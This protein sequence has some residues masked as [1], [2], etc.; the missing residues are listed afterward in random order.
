[1]KR[2]ILTLLAV[3]LL[4]VSSAALAGD[5]D[6][7]VAWFGKSGMA[8][9]VAQSMEAR[10]AEIAPQIK[11]EYQKELADA[12]AL[13]L[14]IQDFQKNKA[15]MVLLRSNGAK[16]VGKV[17]PSIPAFIGASNHPG[18]LGVIQNLDAPEGNITG[19]S[20]A[21]SAESQFSTFSAVVP[22]MKSVFLLLEEGHPSSAINDADTK[23]VCAKLGY[24]FQ[25]RLFTNTDDLLAAVSAEKNNFSVFL[26]GSQAMVM[27]NTA[28][29]VAAAGNTPALAYAQK[30]VKDGA[31]CGL[32]ADD[33]KL[34]ALLAESVVDALVNGQSVSSIPVKFDTK[35]KLYINAAAVEK[36]GLEIPFD[37][38][39][40]AEI[41]E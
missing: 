15:G 17:S 19:V 2:T 18:H 14:A 9:R 1:M 12:A 40:L 27:D 30:P 37:I 4:I 7:G 41:I 26:I 11:L 31:L 5:N 10:L 22:H 39:S 21:L 16:T 29:I 3:N 8:N 20:Y 32:A 24:K 34:G 33:A 28:A 23:A 13:E 25:S 6:V 35:P 36:L 38:L